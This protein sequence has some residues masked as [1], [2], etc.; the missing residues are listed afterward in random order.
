MTRMDWT[1]SNAVQKLMKR[2][3]DVARQRGYSELADDFAQEIATHWLSER[4]QHQTLDQFFI[5]YL[6]AQYGRPGVRSHRSKYEE[7][8]N[9]V[10]LDEAR[11]LAEPAR[12]LEPERSFAVLFSGRE[13]EI[14]G[15]YFI[16]ERTEKSIAA[17]FGVTESRI[18]QLLKPM[19]EKI[20]R[21]A[22]LLDGYERM[23]WDESFLSF[24]IDWVSL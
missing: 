23:E 21:H 2:A 22:I 5:D 4:G 10:D 13:G 18:C 11:N 14:Y 1:D 19:K 15:A 7:R 16:D 20:R 9:Y 17:D 8:R 6:R 3:S 12:D 24:A